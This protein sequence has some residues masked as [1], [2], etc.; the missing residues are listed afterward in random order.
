MELNITHFF[1]TAS[2][3]DYSASAAEIGQDAAR[4]TWRAACDDSA[5]YPMLETDETRD[6]FRRYVRGFGAWTEEEIAQWSDTELNA[7]LIQLIA[8]D[9]REA[10]LDTDAPDWEQYRNDSEAGR[11]PGNIFQGSDGEVYYYVGS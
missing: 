5:D 6:E 2:P 9:I 1:T 8:G 4:V 3:M 10:G 11:V 7:L